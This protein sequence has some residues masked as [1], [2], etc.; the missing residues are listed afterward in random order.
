MLPEISGFVDIP[1]YRCIFDCL[2]TMKRALYF[3]LLFVTLQLCLDETLSHFDLNGQVDLK[4]NSA[5]ALINFH[6]QNCHD[7]LWVVSSIPVIKTCNAEFP[8]FCNISV[9]F[10]LPDFTFSVWQ[11]PKSGLA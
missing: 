1:K 8:F 4:G 3:L 9:H 10:V 11:P 6:L 7:H 5:L 2:F